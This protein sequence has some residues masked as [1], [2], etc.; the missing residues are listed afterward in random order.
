MIHRKDTSC[1]PVYL[2]TRLP[3]LFSRFLFSLLF[4][5]C[6]CFRLITKLD[7]LS[8]SPAQPSFWR[9]LWL[10]SCGSCGELGRSTGGRSTLTMKSVPTPKA[11][12]F[13]G[14]IS[15]LL[16]FFWPLQSSASVDL[17]ARFAPCA[18]FQ[19]DIKAAVSRRWPD[20]FQYPAVWRAQLYQESLCNPKAS[21]HVGAGGIAQFMKGTQRDVARRLGID[22]DRY[23]AR[24]AIDAGAY[25]QNKMTRPFRRR[26]RTP[27]QAYELGA[28][29]YNSGLGNV[30]KAQRFCKNA[31]LWHEISP[32]QNQATG[33]HAVETITY[34]SRIKRWTNQAENTRPWNV[35]DGWRGEITQHRRTQLHNMVPA[36][37]WFTGMSWCTYF[38][39]WD[40]YATAGHC[41]DE[42]AVGGMAPPFLAGK[43][44]S[45]APGLI[46]AALY[47]VTFPKSAPR[48]LQEG[49]SVETIGYPAG[50]DTLT[51]RKGD[52][53]F[54]RS[55]GGDDYKTGGWIIVLEAGPRPTFERE[56]VVGGQSGSPGLSSA[57]EPLCIVVNQNGLVD[58]NSDGRADNSFDCVSLRDAWSVLK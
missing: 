27:E 32:C 45:T 52:A 36:R 51:Y 58:L 25:Y 1:L 30:L 57:G 50:S 14:F 15:L 40:G 42:I 37:R 44:V 13:R 22:F 2:T 16:L 18:I 53:Y 8:K 43:S 34:V 17:P 54:K 4:G 48:A 38:P 35:P 5:L 29:S 3:R 12:W 28:A 10:S 46:D 7:C 6:R 24:Q 41:H 49:E 47:G 55:N 33:H 19:S 26:G 9:R 20:N 31:R 56:P 21:S 11:L 39:L 23:D